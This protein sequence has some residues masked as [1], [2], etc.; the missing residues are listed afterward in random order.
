MKDSVRRIAKIHAKA[1][2]AWA[3]GLEH[4]ART[5]EKLRDRLLE[6]YGLRLSDV[7]VDAREA[8]VG[9]FYIH[10]SEYGHELRRGEPEP[11]LRSLSGAIGNGLG[12]GALGAREKNVIGFVGKPEV[13]ERAVAMFVRLV[14]RLDE[15]S[16]AAMNDEP[17]PNWAPVS[18]FSGG[19]TTTSSTSTSGVFFD[20][21]SIS[22][23][24]DERWRQSWLLGATVGIA[25]RLKERREILNVRL[26]SENALV[27][28]DRDWK[29]WVDERGIEEYGTEKLDVD[30]DA[31]RRG[32]TAARDMA[33]EDEQ[34]EAGS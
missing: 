12:V 3:L 2:S 25:E 30:H 32:Q 29:D 33:L 23:P 4:E 17:A 28:T 10:P 19:T 13:R 26:R 18:I 14:E 21:G 24:R 6:K 11:W 31:V 27:P 7:L 9:Q 20:F 34:I 22:G 16:R 8:E 15:M 5:S 1:E